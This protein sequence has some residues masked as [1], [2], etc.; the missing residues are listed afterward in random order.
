M[1]PL[2]NVQI[3]ER[4]KRTDA[5]RVGACDLLVIKEYPPRIRGDMHDV[6]SRVHRGPL[7]R[8]ERAPA[9]A[10][11]LPGLCLPPSCWRGAFPCGLDARIAARRRAMCL[12]FAIGRGY[13]S[14]AREQAR[15]HVVRRRSIPNAS[16]SVSRASPRCRERAPGMRMVLEGSE[17][18]RKELL[19]V[20]LVYRRELREAAPDEY[21]ERRRG[22]LTLL[23]DLWPRR[24]GIMDF[25]VFFGVCTMPKL[26]SDRCRMNSVSCRMNSVSWLPLALEMSPGTG[27]LPALELVE[28]TETS[29]AAP[30]R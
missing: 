25:S 28:S 30:S 7:V 10:A 18:V 14:R 6:V 27:V 16:V 3:R 13:P 17:Q 5:L 8:D 23:E 15:Q 9:P 19:G 4:L 24:L 1:D 11:T 20:L 22:P 12:C 26:D 2:K 29:V 21:L